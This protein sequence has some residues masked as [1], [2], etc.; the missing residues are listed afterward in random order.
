LDV[1]PYP[2]KTGTFDY[3]FS[4]SVVEHI[5]DVVKH[6]AEVHRVAKKGAIVEIWVPFCNSQ[7]NWT[8]FT[9]KHAFTQYSMDIVVDNRNSN[10]QY[11]KGK[12]DLNDVSL[13]RG[14]LGFF[15]PNFLAKKLCFVF[16]EVYQGIRFRLQVKK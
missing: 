4:N 3:V 12:Y 13:D 5:S 14:A 11:L 16:G 9:H 1:Y 8:D 7:N 15:M 2:F 10:R 6:L